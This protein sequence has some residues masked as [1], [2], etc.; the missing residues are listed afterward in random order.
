MGKIKTGKKHASRS[1]AEI[2]TLSVIFIVI[3]IHALSLMYPLYWAV[4]NALKT[5]KM[6]EVSST[7]LPNPV[8][9]NNFKEAFE[10]IDIDGI[11]LISMIMN[12]VWMCVL[13]TAINTMA[14]SCTAYALARYRFPGRDFLY[15]LVIISMTIPIIGTGSTSY[16]L[17]SALGIIDNP[18]LTAIT[19]FSGFGG[20]FLILYGCF[21]FRNYINCYYDYNNFNNI[22]WLLYSI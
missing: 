15:A 18:I 22:K 5:T 17:K 7:A 16:R 20:N 8:M 10:K 9:W 19:W 11:P 14:C 3:A 1:R 2:I 4:I 21:N 12:S 6:F 13:G